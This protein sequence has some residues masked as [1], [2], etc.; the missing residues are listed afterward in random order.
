M[1]GGRRGEAEKTMYRL[2]VSDLDETLLNSKKEVTPE[3]RAAVGAAGKLGVK[4]VPTSGRGYRSMDRTLRELG[5]YGAAGQYVISFNGGAITENRGNRLLYHLGLPFETADTLY[6]RGLAYDVCIHAYTLD[7]VYVYNFVPGEQDFLRGRMEV[8]EVPHRTLDFLAGQEIIKILYMN[9]D[10]RYLESIA[11]D[12]AD[13]TG[14][15]DVSY[16]SNRY[17]E[18]NRRGV[19]K[20]AGL[21]KLAELLGIDMKDTIAIGDNYNDLSMIEAAGLGVGVRNTVEELK[22]RC[23]YVTEAT[24][25]ESAVAEVIR[26]FV[27]S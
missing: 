13:L 5:L 15:L 19:N 8:V 21:R 2:I 11:E 20:G 14:D 16:S 18:F 26:R 9:T 7:T 6:R 22:P 25:E 10:H 1:R 17:L 27:L 24:C 12:M 3:N 4:F 23:D